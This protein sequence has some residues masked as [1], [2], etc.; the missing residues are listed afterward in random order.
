MKWQSSEIDWLEK[1]A[2]QV[3]IA[4]QQAELYRQVQ[5][6]RIERQRAEAALQKAKEELEGAKTE[7]EIKVEERTAALR[8]TNKQL[9]I[10][11]AERKWA[12]KELQQSEQ[13]FR[14]L[15][16]II[17]QQVWTAQPD[18]RINYVN[19]RT[20]DYFACPAEQLLEQSWQSVLHPDDLP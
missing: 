6:E 16:E 9:L 3:A 14:C 5:A 2:A 15:S 1:L 7:L 8:Q 19:Q 12:E 18:G 4:V 10:K 11:V 20:L 13:R 17:P